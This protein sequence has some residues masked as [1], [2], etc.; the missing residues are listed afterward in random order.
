MSNQPV[1]QPSPQAAAAA[2]T[3]DYVVPPLDASLLLCKL[4]AAQRDIGAARWADAVVASRSRLRAANAAAAAVDAAP[5]TEGERESSG[6]G[7][8]G[9]GGGDGAGDAVVDV[10][11]RVP[12]E[13]RALSWAFLQEWVR[14]MRWA[15]HNNE[16]ALADVNSYQLVGDKNLNEEWQGDFGRDPSVC[17]SW[18][19]RALSVPTT[20]SVVETLQIAFDLTG[21]KAFV[22][23][24]DGNPCVCA[25][26]RAYV[27]AWCLVFLWCVIV[28]VVRLCRCSHHDRTSNDNDDDDDARAHTHAGI[29][30]G[31]RSLSLTTGR[32]LSWTC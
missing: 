13:D 19:L 4:I 2:A 26:V 29:S 24:P 3:A 28:I 22:E 10:V 16:A 25:C 5:S 17:H 1:E 18:C 8:G 30:G 11:D 15:M 31:R 32:R 6:G 21:D 7:G 23:D 12:C 20:L 27:C 9:G 14:G